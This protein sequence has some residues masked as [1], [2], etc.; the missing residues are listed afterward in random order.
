MMIM[1]LD[2]GWLVGGLVDDD[3][4]DLDLEDDL[5]DT[6][7]ERIY[8]MDRIFFFKKKKRENQG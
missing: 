2:D 5:D 4:D 1:V 7:R 3:D 8:G 6:G